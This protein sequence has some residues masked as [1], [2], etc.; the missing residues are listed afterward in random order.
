M[1]KAIIIDDEAHARQSIR[2]ILKTQLKKI[3]IIGEAGN[4]KDSVKLINETDAELLFLDIDLPDGNAFNILNEIEYKKY[5]ILFITAY[6]EYAIKAIKFS[7]FDYILKPI[8]PT[9]LLASVNNAISEDIVEG[10]EDKF[11]AFFSNFSRTTPEQ[12][13]I[14]L[15]TSDKIHVVNINNIIRCEADNAYTTIYINDGTSI[16]VSKSIKS[17]EELLKSY[18]FMRIH[19]S[20][21]INA[22]YISYFN[23]Q[24]GGSLM[25]SDNSTV[26]VSGQ[27]KALLLS[28]LDSL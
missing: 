12:K 3:N 22:N 21:L 17:F 2:T 16:L 8:N 25:M 13:K 6:Q 1:I 7:A 14:V 11:Q 5:K 20:H 9:E 24:E 15:K 27:K 4:V 23:K 18:H 10:Y 19:Q 28:Y 26:P